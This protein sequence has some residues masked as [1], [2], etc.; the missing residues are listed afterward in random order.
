MSQK[1]LIIINSK[2]AISIN[3]KNVFYINLGDGTVFSNYSNKIILKDYR[4]KFYLDYK[5][6]LIFQLQKKIKE[7]NNKVENFI[8]LEIFNLRNDK[9]HNIDLIINILII[10][11]IIKTKKFDHLELYTDDYFTRDI[12]KKMYPKIKLSNQKIKF[13]SYRFELIKITKFYLKSLMV[14][15]FLKFFN[16]QFVKSNYFDEACLSINPIFYKKGNENFFKRKDSIKLNFLLTDETHLNLSLINILKLILKNKQSNL[17]HIENYIRFKDLFYSLIKSY[18]N[19]FLLKKLDFIF[20]IEN[21]DFTEFYYSYIHS[22]FINRSKL[23]IYNNSIIEVLKKFKIKKF[24]LYLF[25]YNFGFYLINL[26]KKKMKDMKIAGYQH[27]IF[28][29]KLL[30]FELIT[31]NSKKLNYLPHE[32]I[33][34]N[35]YSENDYKK[36]IKE[37][38]IKYK[39]SN[40]Q[41][42]IL[43]RDYIESNKQ[44][45]KDH[46]LVLPGTHDAKQIYYQLKNYIDINKKNKKIF[47]FKFHPKYSVTQKSLKQLRVIKSIQNKKFKT[48]LISS[49]STLI[50]DFV[51]LKKKFMVYEF[52]N[53]Q[54]LIS[55]D[56]SK[57]IKFYY[58]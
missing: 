40:K 24:N 3:D 15:I 21:T 35:K 12:F 7:A 39:I 13:K 1:K 56:L 58:L 54:N 27:G 23:N 6:K 57:K 8:E 11:N 25:E 43:S 19:F 49:T 16:K 9:N 38:K 42:S 53:Q 36:I 51:K 29:D 17:V 50:Y 26:I 20:K 28:S 34:T 47:F 31:K 48:V 33:S 44:Q 46:T 37:K 10:K 45:Y 52:D 5:K 18:K 41:T 2:K 14:I 32:I 55:T 4:K 22:S 30:W